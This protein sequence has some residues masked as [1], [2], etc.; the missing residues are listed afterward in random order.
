M[1]MVT[2]DPNLRDSSH[3][4]TSLGRRIEEKIVGFTVSFLMVEFGGEGRRCSLESEEDSMSLNILQFKVFFVHTHS[5]G[6]LKE[7]HLLGL[8]VFVYV[9]VF[10][11]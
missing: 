5:Q 1:E 7:A 6:F 4:N 10:L 3:Y 9:Q 11:G 2:G 8:R